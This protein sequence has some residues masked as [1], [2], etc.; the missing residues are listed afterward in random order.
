MAVLSK[1]RNRA[2]LL[3]IIIGLAMLSFILG[4]ILSSGNSV[5]QSNQNEIAEV[6]SRTVTFQEYEARVQQSAENYKINTKQT[7]IDESTMESLRQQTWNQMLREIIMADEVM[8]LG[9]AVTPEEVFDMVQGPNPHPSVKQAFTNKETGQFNSQDVVRFLKNMDNDKTGA[10]RAQWVAFEKGIRDERV[11]QK[12]NNLVKKGLYV[13]T[14]QAQA[15]YVDDNKTAEI[16]YIAKRFNSVPDTAVVVSEEE[17]KAYYNAH[18]KDYEQEASRKIEYVTFDVVPSEQDKKEILEELAEMKN[19]FKNAEDDSL[20]INANSE[21]KYSENFVKKGGF[22]AIIDS[23]V[24]TL[25]EDSVIG[26]Y[27]END[28]Y[29]ISKIVK[30]RTAPDSVKAR[31]I[32]LKIEGDTAKTLAKADSLKSAIKKGK[33]FA[34]LAAQYSEDP[35]SKEKGGDLGWFQE[36]AMVKPFNDAAFNGKKG[37][38]PIVTSQFGVHLIEIMDKGPESKKIALGSIERKI[39]PSSKTYQQ[40]YGQAS[41][42]SANNQTGDA[43]NTTIT[44]KGLNR[45]VAEQVKET[46]RSIPGLDNPR[47]MIRWAYE[48]EKGEV[49]KVFE[50]GDRFVIAHLADIREKGIATLDNVRT[51]VEIKAR[52]EKKAENFIAEFE[53]A[54]GTKLEDVSAKLN[55]PVQKASNMKFSVPNIAGLGNEPALVGTVFGMSQNKLSKPVKGSSGVYMVMVSKFTEAPE[56]KDYSVARNRISGNLQSRVEYEVFTALQKNADVEDR[57][58]KFY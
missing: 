19:D 40:Y 3:I 11:S 2:G 43:F 39:T 4:D 9:I 28:S 49:S 27:L 35:G 23:L 46:D 42:F 33:K 57:R 50:F 10:T 6:G 52:E 41:E 1:I 38:L 30:T 13:T 29:K 55:A 18:K 48:A 47:E 24:F 14:A 51:E 44:Q 8:E 16:D 15:G 36:G 37:N 21:T 32:L 54:G 58:A 5:F 25:P 31:H 53:K 34:D 56:T 7:S 22:P 12:Y 45:K 26:P 17:L 20:F